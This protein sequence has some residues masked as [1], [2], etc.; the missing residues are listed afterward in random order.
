MNCYLC[1]DGDTEAPVEAPADGPGVSSVEPEQAPAPPA[2]APT[3]DQTA[4]PAQDAPPAEGELLSPLIHSFIYSFSHSFT[5]FA[6]LSLVSIILSILSYSLT[7]AFPEYVK[8]K[9]I[10]VNK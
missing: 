3:E 9:Q 1:G 8:N 5:P 6:P 2:A 7:Y 10:R 4:A